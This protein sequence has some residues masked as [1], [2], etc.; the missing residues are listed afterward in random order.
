MRHLSG[1]VLEAVRD[2]ILSGRVHNGGS[3]TG[4]ADAGDWWTFEVDLGCVVSSRLVLIR[5]RYLVS[6][7][8]AK[9]SQKQR[10]DM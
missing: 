6:K 5:Q 8:Q 2:A 7:S 4:E 10:K 9:P 1:D 3:S